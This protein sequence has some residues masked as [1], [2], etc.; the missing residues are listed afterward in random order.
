M[1]ILLKLLLAH[2]VGDFMLQPE[3]WVVD[4]EEKKIRSMRLYLHFLL[5]GALV[6][7]FLWN[8]NG[9][10]PA[11]F[12]ALLYWHIGTATYFYFCRDRSLGGNR[13]SDC[14]QICFPFR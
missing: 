10:L 12:I 9:W 13:I 4:K 11:L 7:L 3:S 2:F 14:C 1:I 8:G 5:H 6:W